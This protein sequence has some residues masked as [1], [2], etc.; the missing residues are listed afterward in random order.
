MASLKMHPSNGVCGCS[1]PAL[2]VL[3]PGVCSLPLS[4]P[5]SP[6][7]SPMQMGFE[8]LADAVAAVRRSRKQRTLA[9]RAA[10][11]TMTVVAAALPDNNQ[12]VSSA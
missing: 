10:H 12:D 4:H 11:R 2:S 7:R 9:K 1:L 8:G 6:P 5:L 3:L